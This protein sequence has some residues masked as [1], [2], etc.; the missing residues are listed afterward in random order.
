M[1]I[2]YSTC[3]YGGPFKQEQRRQLDKQE[4]SRV[5]LVCI[6]D[7]IALEVSNQLVYEKFSRYGPIIKV[8]IPSP[9]C[10]SSRRARSP[11]SLSSTPMNTVLK[12]YFS[13]HSGQN[14]TRRF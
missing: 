5:L 4:P 10:S 2:Y 8:L 14:G 11:N 1:P 12:K 7:T 9:R 13:L 3:M 6:Y